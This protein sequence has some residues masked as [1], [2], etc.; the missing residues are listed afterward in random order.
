MLSRLFLG[1]LLLGCGEPRVT[2]VVELI[3][4]LV[5]GTEAAEVS[6]MLPQDE[7]SQRS[8]VDPSLDFVVGARVAA[9]EE[10][11]PRLDRR[12]DGEV[13]SPTGQLLVEPSV[14]AQNESGQSVTL[15]ATRRCVGVSC[16][17][18]ET[19][20]AGMCQAPECRIDP[21]PECDVECMADA[22]CAPTGVACATSACVGFECVPLPTGMCG[23]DERCEVDRGCVPLDTGAGLA[24]PWILDAER[25]FIPDVAV[26]PN[27]DIV[28]SGSWQG[29]LTDPEGTLAPDHL[30]AQAGFVIGLD[31]EGNRRWFVELR[32]AARSQVWDVVPYGDGFLAYGLLA[33]DTDVGGMS[34]T[35]GGSRQ[36]PVLMQIDADGGV[37]A[38]SAASVTGSNAQGRG[39]G[40][41]GTRIV[42]AG[43]YGGGLEIEGASLPTAT[44]NSNGFYVLRAAF[45][46]FGFGFPLQAGS[47]TALDDA[48]LVDDT[49]C[50]SGRIEGDYAFNGAM[51]VGNAMRTTG[52]V[53]CTDGAG[54]NLFHH[55][56]ST[57][58]NDALSRLLMTPSGEVVASGYVGAGAVQVDG[59][60]S[61]ATA[62]GDASAVVA[63][64]EPA[65]GLRWIVT[66]GGP[67]TDRVSGIAFRPPDRIAVVGL[68]SAGA[69]IGSATASEGGGFFWELDLATGDEVDVR[70]YPELELSGLAWDAAGSRYLIAG[71]VRGATVFEGAAVAPV[72]EVSALLGEIRR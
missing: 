7:L 59:A 34:I 54:A 35:G 28:V 57:P 66:A 21:G 9:F 64:F 55:L 37:M 70:L 51:G 58:G 50:F 18:G 52:I 42:S 6:V 43:L 56:V 36:R 62:E 22:D 61:G 41:D 33:G 60:P 44:N 3:T 26:A 69:T 25:F 49:A 5:P 13:F 20:V 17:D 11:A 27:G 63:A 39:L 46:S 23:T 71:Q 10:L 4:D 2:L 48:A 1:L 8:A 47:N 15:L 45:G 24:T 38:V 72:G 16:P 65:G 12:V 68:H 67:D 19:C 32:A 31:G 29:A 30:G 14:V 53:L 40:T